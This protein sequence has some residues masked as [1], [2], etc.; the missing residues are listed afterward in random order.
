MEPL[1]SLC[2][3]D[4]RCAF[5]PGEMLRCEYQIDAVERD[6]ML[7]VESSVLWHTEGKG[8]EDLGVHFFERRTPGEAEDG[9]LRQFHRFQTQLP[10]SPLSYD[11]VIVKIRWCVR[12]RLFLRRGKEVFVE[13]PFQLGELRKF[14]VF[15]T[16]ESALLT[17]GP[18]Q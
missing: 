7:A 17:D 11:G 2:L 8:D 16:G 4:Q 3:S 1:I 13:Q 12:V 14:R 18:E 15:P 9:D 5:D 6:E 10:N